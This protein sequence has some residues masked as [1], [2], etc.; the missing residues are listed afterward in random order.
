MKKKISQ[1]L[2]FVMLLVIS[3][4]INASDL[5]LKVGDI[6]PDYLGKDQE[7]NKVLVS[8]NQGKIVVIS[9]WASWCGPCREEIPLLDRIQRQL[10]TET[11]QV[12]AINHKESKS[13]YRRV[14]KAFNASE[15]T[16]THDKRGSIGKKYGV[17]AIPHLIIVGKDGK[18]A[19]QS[20]GYGKGSV[21][22]IVKVINQH[23][24]S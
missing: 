13:K 7:G 5:K 23:L 2:I 9:F 15:I 14:S 16:L 24:E 19:Y 18:I 22:N 4:F 6:P 21:N 1:P 11:I 12:V 3:G 20:R 8:E 17:T 10:G